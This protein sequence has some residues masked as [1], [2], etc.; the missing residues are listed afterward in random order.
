MLFRS[1]PDQSWRPCV[2]YRKLNSMTK[3]Q[4]N[5]LPNI[6]DIL[7]NISKGKIYTQVDLYSGYWQIP[8]RKQDREKTAFVTADGLFQ[9]KVMPFGLKNAPATFQS[10][11]EKVL[12]PV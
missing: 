2:D 8:L 4:S 7:T 1:K 3:R 10:F 5:P 9:W 12:K 6:D 11:M